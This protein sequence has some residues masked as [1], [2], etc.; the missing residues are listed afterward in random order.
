MVKVS[1]IWNSDHDYSVRIYIN[2]INERFKR[3]HLDSFGRYVYFYSND[4]VSEIEI[5]KFKYLCLYKMPDCQ[6]YFK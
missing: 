4:K 2:T 6:S 1:S 3:I 5:T